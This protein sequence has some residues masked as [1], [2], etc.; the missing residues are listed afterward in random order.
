MVKITSS[1]PP[2]RHVATQ[3]DRTHN[4]GGTRAD[5]PFGQ[6]LI[7]LSEH[8]RPFHRL[9]VERFH[10]GRLL[11]FDNEFLRVQAEW[12]NVDDIFD[13]DGRHLRYQNK[14][15]S[16]K[17]PTC[18]NRMWPKPVEWYS[19]NLRGAL[20]HIFV[21]KEDLEGLAFVQQPG[22]KGNGFMPY[23]EW[24]L[25]DVLECPSATFITGSAYVELVKEALG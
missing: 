16:G 13:V 4:D 12:K 15:L 18:Q 7:E 22:H 9:A 24:W 20:M 1:R 3:A 21:R 17:K 10:G 23:M 8:W 14:D 6:P 19:F 11:R 25:E 5:T 2:R